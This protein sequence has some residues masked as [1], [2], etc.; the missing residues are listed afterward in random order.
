MTLVTEGVKTTPYN[1]K[2][3]STKS[4]KS[5]KVEEQKKD[6]DTTLL[7]CSKGAHFK[8]KVMATNARKKLWQIADEAIELLAKQKAE[9]A[10]AL[11]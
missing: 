6:R 4:K 2:P 3:M 5:G 9:E 1:T 11:N 8:A 7:P 10:A